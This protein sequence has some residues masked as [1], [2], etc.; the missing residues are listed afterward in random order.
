M[1]VTIVDRITVTTQ[2]ALNLGSRRLAHFPGH[3]IK[4]IVS[5]GNGADIVVGYPHSTR[6]KHLRVE[7]GEQLDLEPVEGTVP[8]FLGA[9]AEFVE[10]H[11]G[12]LVEDPRTPIDTGV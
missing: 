12:K 4:R 7:F 8:G 5:A 1:K 10:K 2:N 6:T 3:E 11:G 9:L